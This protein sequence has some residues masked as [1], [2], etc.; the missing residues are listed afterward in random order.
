MHALGIV[1]TYVCICMPGIIIV[2]TSHHYVCS[3]T[4]IVNETETINVLLGNN[5]CTCVEMECQ[6]GLNIAISNPDQG[7]LDTVCPV[8]TM[9][10]DTCYSPEICNGFNDT[11]YFHICESSSESSGC[12]YDICFG[13]ITEKLNNSRMDFYVSER[14]ICDDTLSVYYSRRYIKS[15]EITD[16]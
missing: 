5:N 10:A 16:R 14:V 1:P 6:G 4:H 13:N 8:Y 12:N 7:Q 11:P 15:F 2:C 9:H 3:Y